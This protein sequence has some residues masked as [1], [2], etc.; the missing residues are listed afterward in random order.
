M[1]ELDL[2]SSRRYTQSQK[3]THHELIGLP[4]D[5]MPSPTLTQWPCVAGQAD[6]FTMCFF[7]DWVYTREAVLF[8]NFEQCYDVRV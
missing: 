2:K 4:C 8:H 6:E 1:V 3:K 7:W 5:I